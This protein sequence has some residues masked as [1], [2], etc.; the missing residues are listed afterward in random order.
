[1]ENGWF[2][3]EIDSTDLNGGSL[4][5]LG[6]SA[7]VYDNVICVC[8]FATDTGAVESDLGKIVRYTGGTPTDTG[9]L[10]I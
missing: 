1:M 5:T 7:D 9:I 10:L 3:D 4:T 8:T 2:I 6:W